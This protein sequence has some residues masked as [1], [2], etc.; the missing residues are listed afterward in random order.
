VIAS[1]DRLL[2]GHDRITWPAGALMDGVTPPDS[3]SA[4]TRPAGVDPEDNIRLPVPAGAW[5]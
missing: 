1:P 3:L 4:C 5:Y 2:M